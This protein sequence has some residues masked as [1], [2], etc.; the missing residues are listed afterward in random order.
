MTRNS[1]ATLFAGPRSIS[2]WDDRNHWRVALWAQL[3]EGGEAPYWI[4]SPTAPALHAV[5]PDFVRVDQPCDDDLVA[6][7]VMTVALYLGGDEVEGL[8]LDTHNISIDGDTRVLARWW[9][10]APEVVTALADN[11]AGSTRLGL[12]TVSEF[13]LV[14]QGV[15]ERLREL[16]FDTDVYGLLSSHVGR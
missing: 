12:T 15:I 3:V 1:T 16:G 6:S 10:L 9:E 11:V 5:R 4:A 14:T 8:L 7:I 2:P 13:S